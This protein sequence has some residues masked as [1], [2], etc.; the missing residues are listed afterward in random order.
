MK[1][2][3]ILIFAV[4]SLLWGL[5]A[6]ANDNNV[7]KENETVLETTASS[8]ES[9]TVSEG[10]ES[11]Y[12]ENF[13]EYINDYLLKNERLATVDELIFPLDVSSAHTYPSEVDSAGGT[14]L[15]S[16][17]FEDINKD[18]EPEMI[19]VNTE[20][21]SIPESM[22][23]EYM[24]GRDDWNCLELCVRIF[25]CEGEE[26]S[27]I[28][29][30]SA[31]LIPQSGEGYMA[32]GIEKVEKEYYIFAKTYWNVFVGAK[33]EKHF[34]VL[35]INENCEASL[36]YMDGYTHMDEFLD[37]LGIKE[38][39]EIRETT[40]AGIAN[41][42]EN[43]KDASAFETALGQ[44]L[45]CHVNIDQSINEDILSYKLTDYTHLREYLSDNGA[46]YEKNELEQD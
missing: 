30:A 28:S 19:T 45:I 20:K 41:D 8:L 31:T 43:I 12:F 36:V 38:P 17:F 40:L 35:K 13:Y 10:D 15:V 29:K 16:A 7:L 44:K 4:L 27:E 6:C 5:F 2:S 1:K 32:L 22:F 3:I 26:I 42:I 39:I 9:E 46:S 18:G 34:S 37:Q 25:A 23:K 14:G 21:K 24:R 11:A 33:G